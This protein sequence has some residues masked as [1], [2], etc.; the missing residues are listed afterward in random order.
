MPSSTTYEP[1]A[2][3][4][5]GLRGRSQV[6]GH[7]VGKVDMVAGVAPGRN[8]DVQENEVVVG[9]DRDVERRLVHGHRLV[10]DLLSGPR[11]RQRAGEHEQRC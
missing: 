5:I 3:I 6:H 4:L 8:V 10:L 1:G 9:E 7:G 2:V 11:L